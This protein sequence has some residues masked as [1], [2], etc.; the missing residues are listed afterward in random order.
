MYLEVQSYAGFEVFEV[1]IRKLPERKKQN[2]V[3]I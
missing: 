2:L 3:E 1:R